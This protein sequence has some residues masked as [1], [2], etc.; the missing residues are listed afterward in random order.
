[1]KKRNLME[2][3]RGRIKYLSTSRL[4]NVV[5]SRSDSSLKSNR[6]AGYPVF[7]IVEPSN[8]CNLRCP[9]C[10]T[11]Q[12]LPAKRGKMSMQTFK[13][14]IDQMHTYAW[15][16]NLYYLGE[17]LLCDDLPLMITY[18]RRHKMRVSVSSNLNLL[19]EEMADRLID[20][21]LEHLVVSLDGVTQET[22]GIYRIGGDCDTVVRNII[23]L[24]ER[25][26]RKASHYPRIEIQFVVFKH[27]EHEIPGIK[28]L[29]ARLGVGLYFREGTLGG[30]GQSPPLAKD[31]KLA[32]QWLSS[33]K[34]FH[35]DYDY[36][37]RQPNIQK[38]YCGYLWKIATINW[39]GSVFPCCWVFE[40]EHKFGNI[41]EQGFKEIWN[42][43]LFRSS[44]DLFIRN[45]TGKSPGA[46]K[47]IC[48]QCKMFIHK[49]NV[50]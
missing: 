9:L 18:A 2:R 22:Y 36:F 11:G 39:D 15:H 43:E 26:K 40:S 8:F 1:M 7:L 25:K 29:A 42:N 31:Y 21:G 45:S 10:P 16:L 3:V 19:N 46:Q 49:Y 33:N 32:E 41:T 34:E 12:R 4:W 23:M 30:K 17:P 28:E 48:Y 37:K 14:I 24:N 35:Q 50:Q 38:G 44:R 5:K 27:N 6:L 13:R 47:T 20:T